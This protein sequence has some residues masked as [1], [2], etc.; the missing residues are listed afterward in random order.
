MQDTGWFWDTEL[1]L[2]AEKGG[3]AV[4]FVPVHWVED[5]DSRVKVVKTVWRDLKGLARMRSFDWADAQK[6]QRVP[7]AP[8][9]PTPDLIA[10]QLAGPAADVDNG[11]SRGQ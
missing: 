6:T 4:D 2:M 5:T 3:W 8:S 11:G 9:K 10:A 7:R 1:L